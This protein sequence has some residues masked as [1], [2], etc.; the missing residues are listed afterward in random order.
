LGKSIYSFGVCTDHVWQVF[1]RNKQQRHKWDANQAQTTFITLLWVLCQAFKNSSS[2]W[3]CEQLLQQQQ[4]RHRPRWLPL[5]SLHGATVTSPTVASTA[6]AILFWALGAT[7]TSPSAAAAVALSH[8]HSLLGV[9]ATSLVPTAAA[10]AHCHCHSLLGAGRNGHV[11]N[12]GG[13]S[14]T[15]M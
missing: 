6:V 8:C 14:K 13:G 10:A 3:L 12:N 9:T 5:S 2:S 7:A 1:T 15:P 4:Q 11:T